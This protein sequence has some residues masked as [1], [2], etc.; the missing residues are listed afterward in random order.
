MADILT[1]LLLDTKGFDA[2]LTKSKQGVNN[3]QSSITE[4]AKN[5]GAG[6]LKF[7]GAIGVAVGG[8]EAFGKTINSTQ[9]TG[10]A[11]VRVTDQMKASVDS[12]FASIAMG[13]FS[14]FINNLQNVI[15]KAGT[16]ADAL[17]ELATKSLF[18]DAEINNLTTQKNIQANIARDRSRSDKERNDALAKARDYQLK[19]T[20]LQ[21]SLAGTNKQTAYSTLD[22][23]IAK[24]GFKGNVARSTWDWMLKESNRSKWIAGSS[25]YK[26]RKQKAASLM[27]VDPES[28]LLIHS[29]ASLKAKR[30]FDA[31]A[32][33][34]DGRNKEFMY[35]FS[36]M[37]D[38]E[39]SMLNKAMQL[40]AKANSMFSAISDDTLQLNM[41]DAKINGS[42]KTKSGA[43]NKTAQN[44][45]ESPAGSLNEISKELAEARE[46]YNKAATDELRQQ[47]FKVIEELEAKQINLNFRAEFG[48]RDMP[49]LK[50]AGLGNNI[51]SSSKKITK[52]EKIKPS[53][54]K[55]DINAN[56]EYGESLSAIGNIMGNVSGAFDS[57]T[58]SILQWGA[59]LF[60]TIGQAI[61]AIAALIGIK[62]SDTATTN[63]N[64]TAELENAGAK[65]ISAHAGIPFVGV[66]LGVAGIAAIVA[67]MAS[68][69]K[70][71]NGGIVPGGSFS[72]DKVPAL[73]NSGE[74]ILNGSQ[75]ANLFKQLNSGAI[76]RIQVGTLS[77]SLRESIS[78]D[79]SSRSID[80]SGD[81][82][83]RT[84]DLYL[85]LK[86]YM[87]KTG[88]KL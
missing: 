47:L 86:N 23:A 62:T 44:A 66:A 46:K 33:T 28:G 83:I 64:T 60:S 87:N 42:Y 67:A 24:Q 8:M 18:S 31:W 30:E 19:I 13:D 21:K 4:M 2:N 82:K 14:G 48:K 11:Y 79:E 12:F 29:K 26:T 38:S 75:Q 53:I 39:E 54:T 71:A 55:E 5:A 84:S 76:Q 3:Y 61:P 74:M 9:T 70:F 77:N 57:N 69:P 27:D 52:L 72:G 73:L 35:Y 16:L 41:A 37:D 17:D 1:R 10:D 49:E 59:S 88:K 40:N 81:W 20:N 7:A 45:K 43:S 58:A 32:K 34:Q 78:P 15:G 80:V 50:Q 36:E 51:K 63:A 22:T 56:K 85:V 6:I 68:I 65:V 25:E